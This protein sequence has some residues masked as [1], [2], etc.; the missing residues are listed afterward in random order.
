MTCKTINDNLD[1]FMDGALD[2][3]ATTVVSE[4]LT[5]CGDCQRIVSDARE[6]QDLLKAYGD[7][8]VPTATTAFFDQA[9]LTAG[10]NGARVQQRHSWR[11]G[12][13]SAVAA[14]LAL[15]IVGG[16]FF[17]TPEVPDATIPVVTM[18]LEEPRTIN[19]V[20]SSA[21]DLIDATLTVILPDGIELAGFEGQREIRWETSLTAGRNVLQLKL[22]ATS[23]LGGEILATLQHDDDDRSFR[24]R[25]TVI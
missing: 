14:G 6:L 11:K 1:D 12:F 21:V 22:I 19:L 2:S 7:T 13:G 18:T 23:P 24:L 20:F 4:H 5:H 16:L 9:L 8:D 25:V 3:A 15:W 17:K 10:R